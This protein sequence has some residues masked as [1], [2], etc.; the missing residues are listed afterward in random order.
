MSTDQ[1]GIVGAVHDEAAKRGMARDHRS[2][3][4]M[5]DAVQLN[6]LREENGG[7]IDA[8]GI[9]A[10]RGRGRAPGS[11]NKRN[12]KVAQMIVHK[13]GD[14]M[15]GLGNFSVMPLEDAVAM[16][17]LAD[18]V[19]REEE[20]DRIEA[21]VARLSLQLRREE[22]EA[23]ADQLARQLMKFMARKQ[24]SAI[25][26]LALQI[27]VGQD[28]MTYVHG[29]QPISVDVRE[30]TDAVVIIPGINA[31]TDVSQQQL[32]EVINQRGLDALDFQNMKLLDAP[33]D[34]DFSEVGAGEGDDE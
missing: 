31:P 34:A 3:G 13:F 21:M 19:G 30:K 10:I 12:Q 29:R 5:P 28:L 20:L 18:D 1:P 16:V 11:R 14:P 15:D 8:D 9:R 32:A 25:D 2:L 7:R 4:F 26:V 24:I 27:R 22:M 33:E 6:L 17:R 23:T